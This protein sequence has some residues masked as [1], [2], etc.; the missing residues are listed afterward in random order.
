MPH[1]TPADLRGASIE[2]DIRV[3]GV[4]YLGRADG[5]AASRMPGSRARERHERCYCVYANFNCCARTG[6]EKPGY[7]NHDADAGDCAHGTANSDL[8]ASSNRY[9]NSPNLHAHTGI[10]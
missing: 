9:A 7:A 1:G 5:I 4:G 6:D 3:A 10:R 2:A 8:C